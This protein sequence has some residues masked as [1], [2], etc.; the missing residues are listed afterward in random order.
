MFAQTLHLARLQSSLPKGN[1]TPQQLE[2]SLL[3]A[4]DDD[5]LHVTYKIWV[6][7]DNLPVATIVDAL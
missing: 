2:A 3:V 1:N 5:A 4:I 6:T 7:L